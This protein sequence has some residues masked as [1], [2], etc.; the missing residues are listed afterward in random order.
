M[1]SPFAAAPAAADV[2]V[3]NI[4]QS[5][6]DGNHRVNVFARAQGFTAGT[7][8]SGYTLE[9]IEIQT[10]VTTAALTAQQIAT[11]K[12]EL[13]SSSSGKPGSKL[14]DL[15]VPSSFA[16][17]ARAS[18]FSAPSGTTLA[19]NTEYHVVVY[20][21]GETLETF[22]ITLNPSDAE[23]SGAAAGWSIANAYNFFRN[24]AAVPTASTTWSTTGTGNSIKIRVNGAAV[25]LAAPTGLRVTPG[26][27]RLDVSWTAPPGTVTGYDVHYTSAAVGTVA[28]DA[29]VTAGTNAATGW[30]AASRN[31]HGTRASHRIRMVTGG[32]AHRVRVR[33]TSAGGPGAWAF[34]AG[35]PEA[36]GLPGLT[37]RPGNGQLALS[38]TRPDGDFVAYELDYTSAPR[39]G[40]GAVADAA[41][42]SG[43]N[44]AT[45]WV[46]VSAD[47]DD[48]H[49]SYTIA[50]LTNGRSYRVRLRTAGPEGAYVFA[51]GTPTSN[52][53]SGLT[54]R[55]GDRE[56]TARW[57]APAGVDVVRYE[58][59]SKLKSAA[60][61]PNTDTDV[62]GTSHTFTG[63]AVGET[64]LVRVRSV[65][66]DGMSA[67]VWTAPVEAALAP[68]APT[69]LTVT[70]G[71]G[72]LDLSWTAPPVGTVTAYWVDY[73]TSTTVAAD[74]RARGVD[75]AAGWVALQRAS[76]AHSDATAT[77]YSIGGGLTIGTR[78]RVRVRASNAG[79]RLVSPWVE[80][81]G[82]PAGVP[83]AALALTGAAGAERA[84]RGFA[85]SPEFSGRVTRYTASVPHAV[86][87]VKLTARLD[88]PHPLVRMGPRGSLSRV[89]NGEPG[90]AIALAVGANVIE[91]RAGALVDTG[92]LTTYTVTVTR[93]AANA[94]GAPAGLTV[95]PGGGRL[96]LTWTAPSGTVTGYDVHYTSAFDT[97]VPDGAAVQTAGS[98]SAANGW[99][100]VGRSGT[101]ASQ[102]ITGLADDTPYRVRVRAENASGKGLWA[103]A[104]Y[105]REVAPSVPRNVRVTPGDD[106]LTLSWAAP[107]DWGSWRAQGFEIQHDA[108]TSF[109]AFAS[110]Y[111]TVAGSWWKTRFTMPRGPHAS[112]DAPRNGR[113][114]ALRI[115]AVSQQPGT[116]GS[117][118]RHFQ[119]SDW[120]T[121]SGTPRAAARAPGALGALTATA[122]DAKLD[123]AWTTPSAEVTG[124]EVHVTTATTTAVANAAAVRSGTYAQGWS[125]AGYSD[126]GLKPEL[127]VS[128]LANGA[129]HRVR[130]RA[131]N[132][133]GNGPWSFATA[134]PAAAAEP[135]AQWARS[136]VTVRETDADTRVTLDILLSKALTGA[137]EV[138][139]IYRTSRSTATRDGANA[140]WAYLP[141]STCGLGAAGDTRLSCT[142]VIKGDDVLEGDETLVFLMT[143]S[144]FMAV[145]SRDTVTVTIEDDDGPTGLT[146]APGDRTLDVSWTAPSSD[147]V[148]YLLGITSATLADVADDA[149]ASGTNP[150]V[151]WVVSADIRDTAATSHTIGTLTN[152]TTY[153][154][155]LRTFDPDSPWVFARGTP[156]VPADTT[157][158][159]VSAFVPGDGTTTADA[160]TN[161]TL[162]FTEAVRKDAAN[163]DFTG[164]ADLSAVLTLARTNAS[165]TAIPYTA[166]IDAGKT[167]ITLDPTDDLADGAV[168][169]GISGAYYDASGNA[170]SAASATFTVAAPAV[171]SSDA[172]LS[173]LAATTSTSSGGAF[174]AL[175]I[176][177][178]SA[179]TTSYTASVPYAT[180]HVK[181]TPTV[182]ATG[183]ARVAVRKGSSGGFTT[184]TSGSA[185]RAIAL[186]VGANPLTVRVTAED[187]TVK[188]Y[189]VTVTRGAQAPATVTLSA[190]PALV[191][192]GRPVTV[193]ATLSRA[194]TRAVTIPVT[195]T[196]GSAEAEDLGTLSGI[197]IARG[198][199]SGTAR[200][201]TRQDDDMDDE[202]F[203]VAITTASLPSG[204]TA[205][206]TTSV[207]LTID[208]DDTPTVNLSF[209]PRTGIE[210][211]ESVT[212][213]ATLSAALTGAVTIPLVAVPEE[214]TTSADY[215]A[216]PRI[217]IAAGETSGS[218]TLATT[219]DNDSEYESFKVMLDTANLPAQVGAGPRWSVRVTIKPRA[220]PVVWLAAPATVNEGESVT[221]TAHLSKAASQAVEI[222]VTATFGS[223]PAASYDIPIAANATSGTLAIATRQD[224]DSRDDTL[225]VEIDRRRLALVEPYIQPADLLSGDRPHKVAISIIDRPALTARGGTAREGQDEAVTFTVRL[226]Y[227]AANTVTV[228][229]TTADAA[230]DWQG[231][232][233][234][235]AGADYTARSGSLTFAVGETTKTVSVPVLDDAVDEGS[236]HF[237][238][239]LSNPAGAYVK[240]GHGEAHGVITNDDHLQSMWLARFGRT[241]G[242]HL[243]DAVSG[244]LDADL[245]PGAH[246]TVAG[247]P[248]DLANADDADALADVMAGLA[249]RFGEPGAPASNDDPFAPHGA[250]RAW[251]GPAG[252]GARSMTGRELLLGSAF[253]LATDGGGSAPDLAAW[254]R[255]AHGRF[256]GEHADDSGATRVDGDVLTGTLG[257]DADF[258]RVLA[259]VAV[260]LSEGDGTFASPGVDTGAKGGIESTM[261][262]VSPY[263]RFKLTERVSAWG[264]AGWGTGDMTIAFDDATAPI[265]TGIGMRMGALG[266]RGALLEQDERGGMDL[267]LKADAFFVRMD[268]EKAAN[269]A[270]VTADASQVRLVLEGGRAFAVSDTATFRPA[271]ELGVRHDGGDAE[272][273]AGLEV[274]GGVAFTDAASGLSLEAKARL[275]AAHADSGYEE[276]GMSATARLDPGAQGRGLSFSLAP[277]IG[278]PSSTAERL[279]GAERPSELAPGSR[280]E[281]TRGLQAEAGYGLA[282]SGGRFTATPNVGLGL[283]D[284]GA[285]DWRIG[286]R[287]TSAVPGD[288]GFELNL[289]ATRREAAGGA[290]PPE[291]GVMLRGAMR[292]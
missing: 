256:D 290:T 126:P 132:S 117:M 266:A 197:R 33:A 198:R 83:L 207:A 108:D 233:P 93:L 14:A 210:A 97:A 249:Q 189:T 272:T 219:A 74:A 104:R 264:L 30:V 251:N 244:R 55:P 107:G 160:G 24:D 255:V 194:L 203:T 28:N 270:E 179:A 98:A 32:L 103:H 167:V 124:Y 102:A 280:F 20:T 129:A 112:R 135:V 12:V 79:G 278:T 49:T 191:E 164:H 67:G 29:A 223:G 147:F 69:G 36:L 183:I 50:G 68:A 131:V 171:R 105:S 146:V 59:Q 106:K 92:T 204:V 214:G 206:A 239:R 168:Y 291:H 60:A 176:G 3:S 288:P 114:Y 212:L 252:A 84:Y 234:A 64:Y 18:T 286:W 125:S 153:R 66:R 53:P 242:R 243:T 48:T 35:T 9:S 116:D 157:A 96:D 31:G 213:T 99:V 39:T 202:T 121:V 16:T 140:D 151:S 40:A 37:V 115:R 262:T 139:I 200:I 89:G 238:L 123:L 144:P 177:T 281:A 174:S 142:L 81:A 122:G 195:V 70:P 268:S 208:D 136:S 232:S 224:D 271:L 41:A 178:F 175:S 245:T 267:A 217:R 137:S 284:G 259:G 274:G 226:S 10:S 57:T 17:G 5:G 215:G 6:L 94:P 87:H 8:G 127:T 165:G 27:T 65:K 95:T 46:A 61:W 143:T 246:A 85:L 13:W 51:T 292:W 73:T 110:A 273:G 187:G 54:L 1:L 261:T 279:W 254:G 72:R 11:I 201:A 184:V 166:S 237:L 145:G 86:T 63:L 275:L 236:E 15:T 258:G 90:G 161:I 241:V 282:L 235:T 170:G 141:G 225:T 133:A 159:A 82:T 56:L 269:S 21:T 257:A 101:A 62:T 263:L 163:A 265:R 80:G 193:E 218:G 119:R 229:Y 227:A 44:A 276:W 216:V 75:E 199:T 231:A 172:N 154:V 277:T 220:V 19:A 222:P 22:F 180:T 230:G 26:P 173:A 260:S 211:G 45:H 228:A 120:V 209:S 2:L 25:P 100:A 186:G 285:R 88:A 205:G 250:G 248:L 148:G 77:S 289:D 128:A 113:T 130:V 109:H 34:G 7:N 149:A 185:S 71:D 181:L 78:Y 52:V 58:V 190:A 283:A 221:V 253:H 188:D 138:T 169:V 192:E 118:N 23:D 4:G 47:V 158:P 182:A 287:L 38:W 150:A 152:G 111:W 91:V 42:S 76:G 240:T 196:R 134:T 156:Q 162:T 155:R 247:Q 43:S